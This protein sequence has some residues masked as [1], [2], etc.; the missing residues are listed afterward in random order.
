MS[1]TLLG[2]DLG[3]FLPIS[4]P[5][6][7]EGRAFRARYVTTRLAL[8][9]QRMPD[10]INDGTYSLEKLGAAFPYCGYE[11]RVLNLKIPV[12]L[13]DDLPLT[14]AVIDESVQAVLATLAEWIPRLAKDR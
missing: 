1:D 12:T 5:R 2:K 7:P 4:C 11:S 3:T 13:R 8:F 6:T 14:E 9:R 10:E